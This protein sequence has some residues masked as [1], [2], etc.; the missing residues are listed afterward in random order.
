MRG[1]LQEQGAGS[2]AIRAMAAAVP[3]KAQT[4]AEAADDLGL[5]STQVKMFTRLYGLDRLPVDPDQSLR[6]LLQ[7]AYDCL[8]AKAPED[9]ANARYVVHCHTIPTVRAPGDGLG[10]DLGGAEEF[11]LTMAH[12]ASGLVA[13]D[14][15]ETL[16]AP[17][18]TAVVLAG[19]K[20]FH[21]RVRVIRDNTLMSDGVAAL[22]VG[23]GSGRWQVLGT[24]STHKGAYA[25]SRGHP[26]EEPVMIEDYTGF[27]TDHIR[28]ALDRF[29]CSLDGLRL[30]LPHNVNVVSWQAIAKFLGL[31]DAAVYTRNIPRYGHCFGADPFLN[32]MDADAEG[33]LAPGDKLLCVSVGMG[34]TAASSLIGIPPLAPAV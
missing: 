23:R 15:L 28:S 7:A 32:L 20:A 2:L 8:A 34:V 10:L 22:L 30:I 13:L 19:E 31:P 9:V 3:A 16:L 6:E 29:G 27:L 21:Q 17:G 5:N 4:V 14:M 25:L 33:Q 11:S 18:E 24:H 12:C 26:R 1:L